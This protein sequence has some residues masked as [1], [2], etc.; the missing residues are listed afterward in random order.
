MASETSAAG[1]FCAEHPDRRAVE[2]C[3]RCGTYLCESCVLAFGSDRLCRPCF[4]RA[5]ETGPRLATRATVAAGGLLATAVLQLALR[6]DGPL[7]TA[8]QPFAPLVML[9]YWG[10]VAV[11]LAWFHLA[12]SKARLLGRG[13]STTPG[14]AVWSWLFPVVNLVWPFR[15]LRGMPPG[16]SRA[17]GAWQASWG[18]GVALTALAVLVRRRG[19]EPGAFWLL[20]LA[21]G[22]ML[23]AALFGGVVIR[24]VTESLGTSPPPHA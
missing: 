18:A 4:Q 17:L 15:I 16:G 20:L 24:R 19:D 14:M 11:F 12:V 7:Q 13:P 3:R 9:F 23:V 2:T 10:V 6:V 5:L 22:L 21:E 8:L 1:P